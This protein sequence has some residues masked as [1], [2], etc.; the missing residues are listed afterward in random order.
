MY[1][2][3]IRFLDEQ[4]NGSSPESS[5][6][7]DVES[8]IRASSL[9]ASKEKKR[10]PLPEDDSSSD[11]ESEDGK[12][13]HVTKKPDRNSKEFM[14]HRQRMFKQVKS[15]VSQ[16]TVPEQLVVSLPVHNWGAG[17]Q[18]LLNDLGHEHL[19]FQRPASLVQH[20]TNE[21]LGYFRRQYID[22]GNF[23]LF[24]TRASLVP[25]VR[26]LVMWW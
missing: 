26:M 6:S 11:E 10:F 17:G 23:D 12:N 14:E 24:E 1:C 2:C 19:S 9:H 4:P 3:C 8:K 25:E 22:K 5:N 20:D 7:S 21:Y 15:L 13:Q 18:Q 16:L